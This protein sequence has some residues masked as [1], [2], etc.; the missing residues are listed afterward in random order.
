MVANDRSLQTKI[1]LIPKRSTDVTV[2]TNGDILERAIILV[3]EV[4][5]RGLIGEKAIGT[6]NDPNQHPT[7]VSTS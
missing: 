4:F 1:K 2:G 7:N 3:T 5:D 6:F